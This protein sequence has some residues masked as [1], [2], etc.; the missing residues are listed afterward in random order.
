MGDRRSP[1]KPRAEARRPA[2]TVIL[3]SAGAPDTAALK[4][5]LPAAAIYP[6]PIGDGEAVARL[7]T[8]R[9]A[10]LVI[11]DA[12]E[13][14]PD[15]LVSL[16]DRLRR[17]GC[18]PV[19]IVAVVARCRLGAVARTVLAV[20]DCLVAP[21]EAAEIR[22]VAEAVAGHDVVAAPPRLDWAI[23]GLASGFMLFDADDRLVLCNPSAREM[24]AL[25][26]DVIVPGASFATLATEAAS[27]GAIALDGL[28]TE[29][30]IAERMA[31]HR[32][33]RDLFEVRLA[34]G[35]WLQVSEG[36][37]DQGGR[38]VVYVDITDIKR[39]EVRFRAGEAR[40]QRL[41]EI[42]VALSAEKDI[43]RLLERILLEA[44]RIANAEGGTIYLRADDAGEDTR[45]EGAERR[46]GRDRRQARD[47]RWTAEPRS[48]DDRRWLAHI[49]GGRR[50]SQTDRRRSGERRDRRDRR[51][52]RDRLT[53]AIVRNTALG[54]AMGGTTGRPITFPPLYLHDPETGRESF[55]SVATLVALSGQTVNIA[56]AYA[57][58][59]FDFSATRAFDARNGY[60]SASFLTIPMKSKTDAVI[61]VL[62]LINARDPRTGTI[63]P[64]SADDQ[65][66]VEALASQAAVALEN[67][68]LLE[69]QRRLLGAFV[70][71]IASAIDEKSP[72]TGGHCARVP[73]LTE[74]LAE[75]ACASQSRPFADFDL[76]DDERYELHIAAWLHDCGKV[77]T[78]EHLI[79]KPT[80]LSAVHDRIE[81]VRARFAAARREAEARHAR[82]TDGGRALAAE[83]AGLARDL[84]FLER[85][86]L[87]AES[88]SETDKAR[89]RAIARRRWTDAGGN[90]RPLLTAEEVANL[91]VGR[92]TLTAEERAIVNDHIVS[93][94]EMLEKLP[95]PKAL[96]RV[97]EY[98]G[99]HH[100][101]ID[102]SG[103][104]RGLTRAQMSIPAR[105]MAIADI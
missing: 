42:G 92:G 79:D 10:D 37:T 54:L 14:P 96:A 67:K 86:N 34:D 103:Y 26:A 75:A 31:R 12:G 51:P 68:M 33:A 104:P 20:D 32:Q 65:A 98:A 25:I 41:T 105:I 87:G 9:A 63:G 15:G 101:H 58:S 69:G 91:S 29:T 46:N 56:D 49:D 30:W 28:S 84:A 59:A 43:D 83:L 47:R 40:F 82:A 36:R 24:L 100:E 64:F 21:L 90:P 94:I 27:R 1:R 45:P 74:M 78:P 6:A 70:Q 4:T 95:F 38:V 81:T 88:M 5:A 39:R 61:G 97:P 18:R 93:T 71:V 23:E 22:R 55:A 76:D 50:R 77:T 19:A 17:P 2:P 99:G 35:R 52:P 80:K 7:V 53:F 44:Q 62:Q 66:V 85:V 102:G 73:V 3:A 89:V 11:L 57:E 13:M 48:G 72:H 16:V 60:R 8:E